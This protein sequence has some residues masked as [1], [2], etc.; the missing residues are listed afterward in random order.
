MKKDI[1][2]IKGM[3]CA[4]CARAVER[5]ALKLDGVKNAFVNLVSEKMIVDYEEDNVNIEEITSAVSKAGYEAYF[6]DK[7]DLYK[8][9]KEIELKKMKNK[10]LLSLIFTIPLFI[11]AMGPMVGLELPSFGVEH[12]EFIYGLIQII[13]AIPVMIINYKT[14][15]TGFKLLFRREPNMDSLIAIGT[16]ASFVFSLYALINIGM[17][18]SYFSHQLYFETVSVILTLVVFGK[19]LEEK[20]KGKSSQ[21]IKKLIGLTPKTA[22]QIK[23]GKEIQVLIEDVLVDDI[24]IVRPGEKIPV[25]GV[26]IKGDTYV[27]ESMLTGESVPVSKT[28]NDKVIGGSINKNGY[29]EYKVTTVLEE[30]VLSQIIKFVSDAQGSKAPIATLAD[31][32]SG[33]FVPIVLIIAV[34]SLI[35]WLIIDNTFALTS[36]V[37]VLIIACPCALGLATPTAI[38]VGTGKG[39]ENGILF[40]NATALESIH[41]VDTII[42]DKTGTLTVGHPKVAN[43]KTY[44]YEE[45]EILIIAASLEKQSEHPLA[46]SIVNEAL[47]KNFELLQ[48]TDFKYTTGLGITGKLKEKEVIIGNAKMM[49][50]NNI[51][52]EE[53]KKELDMFADAG[54]TAVIVSINGNISGIIAIADVIKKDSK[55]VIDKI[56]SL[57]IE[58][59]MLTGDNE[60]TAKSI[61]KELNIKSVIAEVMPTEKG[62]IIKKLQ[63]EGKKVAM[64]GDGINDAPA[65]ALSN[66][67]IAVGNGT[68]IAIESADIVLM[69]NSIMG[70]YNAIKLSNQTVRNIKQ[71]LFWAFLYNAMGIPVAAGL[72]KL[73]GGI[74]LNPM[75]AALAMSFSSISVVLNALRLNRFKGEK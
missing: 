51:L 18:N 68:D 3:T 10:V 20:A 36:F 40:K 15:F 52:V 19:Y 64:V 74:S 5:S 66:V 67:G 13:L 71:N 59:I 21:A 8:D 43:I 55:K 32:V 6:E 17:E 61:A 27:D 34:I 63:D 44:G 4:S 70:V 48:I 2:K 1:L 35:S 33:Y 30:G 12:N 46:E 22:W 31:I 41:K 49:E 28:I 72:F 47:E 73:F 45:N 25:D 65:L 50:S 53:Y 57:G 56:N 9:D 60:K 29:I 26:I 11:I 54:K 23:D 38:M 62:N 75:I 42:F 69:N 37:S 24:L 14:Y 58:T 16:F 39:A 7:S